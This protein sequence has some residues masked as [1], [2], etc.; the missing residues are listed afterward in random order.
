MSSST[1]SAV[2]YP[3]WPASSRNPTSTATRAVDTAAASSSTSA[4]KN[5]TRNVAM[6]ADR[7]PSVTSVDYVRL[8][9]GPAEHLE[10]GQA[11]HHVQ[12]M[13]AEPRQQP[14]LALGTRPRMQ[15]DKAAKTGISGKVTAMITAEIQSAV[16]TVASTAAGTRQAEYQL[17][18]VPGEIGVQAIQSAGGHGGDLTRLL[19]P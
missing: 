14:P 6:V 8:R 13:A 4:D 11:L 3:R 16:A 7:Y 5:A 12:E 9:R 10:R 15:A 18:Q 2:W 19:P 17:R 1:T